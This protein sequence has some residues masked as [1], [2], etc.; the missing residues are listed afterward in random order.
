MLFAKA[1]SLISYKSSGIMNIILAGIAMLLATSF[2]SVY[3][4]IS[5]VD[6]THNQSYRGCIQL[7]HSN[8]EEAFETSLS[9]EDQG[10]GLP[11]RHCS[12]I[13]LFNLEHYREAAKRLQQLAKDI[14]ETVSEQI[15]TDILGQAG[16]ALYTVGDFHEALAVQDAA[17]KLYPD[18]V[19]VLIDRALTNMELG[20]GI[21]TI[22]D[23]TKVL[24]LEADHLEA[25]T[26]R[27]AAYRQEEKFAMALVDLNRVLA[28]DPTNP[29]ALLERGI[30]YRLQENKNA[31]RTDWLKLIEYHDGRPAAEMAQRNLQKMELGEE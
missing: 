13:A 31:A 20:Q 12:A 23:L 22:Q 3:A 2:T 8:P 6:F 16:L 26:Y 1:Y 17:L 28:L 11:A 25:L 7:A 4:Q 14:P 10:G 15:V 5:D 29:E 18:N 27:G 19:T 30:V 21:K 24:S 9:W